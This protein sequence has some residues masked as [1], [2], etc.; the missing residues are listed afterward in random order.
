MNDQGLE[1]G[2]KRV[3]SAIKANGFDLENAEDWPASTD[4]ES[5]RKRWGDFLLA[6]LI[7]S[8]SLI[9][10]TKTLNDY[11]MAW[12]EGF[13]VERVERLREWFARIAGDTS[14]KHRAWSPRMSQLDRRQDYLREAGPAA[15]SPWSRESIR[16]YWQFAREEPSGH[17]PFYALLGLAGWAVSQHALPPPDSYRF[18]PVVLFAMT[19]GVIYKVMSRRY[20]RPAGWLSAI[21]LLTMPRM[22]AHAHLASYDVPALCL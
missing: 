18:G 20:G 1:R 4:R 17:P 11:G 8:G 15:G 7:V 19:L 9:L 3:S 16:Y 14:L 2:I 21:G 6:W 22:F 12:D 13:T 10:L 5:F